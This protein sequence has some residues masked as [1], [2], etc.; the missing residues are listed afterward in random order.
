MRSG[1]FVPVETQTSKRAENAAKMSA[2][3]SETG[4]IT[5]SGA[6]PPELAH[7]VQNVPS[8]SLP[9]ICRLPRPGARDPI[10]GA[11]RTWLLEADATLTPGERFL[12]RIRKRGRLRGAVFIN[13]AKLLAFLRKAEAA[14]RKGGVCHE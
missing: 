8:P 5:A 7:C 3:D 4:L 2:A 9:E 12:F 14:D 10:S 1:I 13:V 11:S 6:V